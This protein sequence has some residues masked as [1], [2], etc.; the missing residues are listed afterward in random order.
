MSLAEAM[1]S[2]WQ[3]NLSVCLIAKGKREKEMKDR[4]IRENILWGRV[5]KIR[6]RLTPEL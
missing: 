4:T 6:V 2:Q 1:V 5:C 3:K